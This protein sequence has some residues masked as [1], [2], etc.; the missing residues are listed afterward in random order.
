MIML[1]LPCKPGHI[2]SKSFDELVLANLGDTGPA[3]RLVSI[4]VD[5]MT[6]ELIPWLLRNSGDHCDN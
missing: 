4:F 2:P 6:T 1:L 3:Y 5:S